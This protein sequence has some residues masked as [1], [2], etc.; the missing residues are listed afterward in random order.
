M[1]LTFPDC[2]SP[3][4][5]QPSPAKA[6]VYADKIE[7]CCPRESSP[8]NKGTGGWAEGALVLL[9]G[10]GMGGTLGIRKSPAA[11][12]GGRSVVPQN[13]RDTAWVW[14]QLFKEAMMDGES[15]PSLR[16]TCDWAARGHCPQGRLG[17]D[18]E[19]RLLASGQSS[20]L[21]AS[22]PH[23]RYRKGSAATDPCPQDL[24]HPGLCR[25]GCWPSPFVTKL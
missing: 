4:T 21:E 6:L 8:S 1:T 23:P 15:W 17:S 10:G 25:Q 3:N 14:C 16:V 7:A 9:A 18:Q 19:L 20:R 11:A 13:S 5:A 24:P 2:P 22:S 12:L